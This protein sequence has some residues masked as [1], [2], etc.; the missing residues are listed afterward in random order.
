[1]GWA[2]DKKVTEK[3]MPRRLFGSGGIITEMEALQN[4][5]PPVKTRLDQIADILRQL[6]YDEMMD[7]DK[8][9]REC[10]DDAITEGHYASLLSKW[11]KKNQE[12]QA[13]AYLTAEIGN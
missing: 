9:F 11:Y 2:K 3:E 1:M 12:G 8:Q 5:Q 4:Y 10:T 13:S 7:L 6:T